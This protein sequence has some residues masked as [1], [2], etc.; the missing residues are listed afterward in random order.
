MIIVWNCNLFK[1][2]N[3]SLSSLSPKL[4]NRPTSSNSTLSLPLLSQRLRPKETRNNWP[5]AASSPNKARALTP[6]LLDKWRENLRF[7]PLSFRNMKARIQSSPFTRKLRFNRHKCK[8][9]EE[10]PKTPM[11]SSYSTIWRIHIKFPKE[12]SLPLKIVSHPKT[13]LS[14]SNPFNLL[15]SL[16]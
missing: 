10:P 14:R 16:L 7:P 6:L 5:K 9:S 12:A 15:V 8:H 4:T 1:Q 3:H 11:G 2:W 13:P